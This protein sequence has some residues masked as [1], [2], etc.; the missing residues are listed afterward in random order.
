[1]S[2]EAAESVPAAEAPHP[3]RP[4]QSSRL[5]VWVQAQDAAP[6]VKVSS[7]WVCPQEGDECR[8]HTQ[9]LDMLIVIFFIIH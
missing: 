6:R 5:Q 3:L 1:M 2:R 9:M 8:G 4:C 7:R